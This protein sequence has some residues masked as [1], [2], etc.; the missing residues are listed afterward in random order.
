[1]LRFVL[2]LRPNNGQVCVGGTAAIDSADR[3]RQGGASQNATIPKECVVQSK[4]SLVIVGTGINPLAHCSIIARAHIEQAETLVVHVPDALGMI[5]LAEC[6][7]GLIDLQHCY[8]ETSN[9]ADA[10]ELMVRRIVEPVLAGKRTVAVFYGHPGVFVSPSHE[11][12]KRVRAAG[13]PATMLPGI[14][15]EDCL[16]ADVGFDPAE[17]GCAQFEA[18]QFLFY[19]QAVQASSHLILW[20]LGVVGDHTLTTRV[21]GKGGLHALQEKLLRYFPADHRIAIYEAP[22]LAVGS[23]RIDWLPLEALAEARVSEISTLFVPATGKPEPDFQSLAAMGLT[24]E[25]ACGDV[26]IL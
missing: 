2:G 9:R 13:L 1:M 12:I 5:W 19:R 23:A 24:E 25:L 17:A 18:T 21:P 14:S 10:Y 3:L 7:P 8:R 11:A 15:A 6:N 26:R 4:G 16:I 22:T 20:Q